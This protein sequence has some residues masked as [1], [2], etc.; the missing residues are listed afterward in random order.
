MRA[1]L[2]DPHEKTVTEVTA[3]PHQNYDSLVRGQAALTWM[4]E[5]CIPGHSGYVDA[6]GIFRKQPIWYFQGMGVWGPMLI[7]GV[8]DEPARCLPKQVESLVRWA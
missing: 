2:V 4:T 7:V 5:Q 3:E 1:V 6:H 8:N